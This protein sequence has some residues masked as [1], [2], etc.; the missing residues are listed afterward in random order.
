M[1]ALRVFSVVLLAAI[2]A[3]AT[4]LA[5]SFQEAVAQANA[6][7]Q[8]PATKDYFSQVLLPYY[9]QKYGPVLQSC[10]ATVKQPDSSS[11]SFVAAIGSDGRV[12][13]LYDDKETN[14]SRCL[15]DTVK[16][17]VFPAPPVSP[18]YLHVDMKFGEPPASARASDDEAPPLVLGAN[19]YSYTFGVPQGWKFS[20]EQ[21]Q[22]RGAALAFFP[23]GG[24]FNHSSSVIYVNEI[25]DSC[26]DCLSQLWQSIATTLREV[27]ADSPAVE[28]ATAEPVKTKD[29]GM[30][31]IRILK[32]AM[33][34]RD[35]K[36]G[37]DREAVAFLGHDET[38]IMVVL[39][40]RDVSAWEQ[41][42]AAFQQVVAGH[43]YFTCNSPDL[44]V[45]C[46]R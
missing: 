31:T 36:R 45:P 22:A 41:D 7:E 19:K 20:F 44:A 32:G 2:S 3:T 24:S 10:F 9:G 33:D 16:N 1:N 37:K 17:E 29:G 26:S 21:A 39:T 11:F 30:A 25:G 46:Q 28:I 38:I 15:R 27:K 34:P 35:P 6:Q 40:A 18:Y 42:Y 14:I 5:N 23:R 8:A 12:V 13:R 4:D 43:K